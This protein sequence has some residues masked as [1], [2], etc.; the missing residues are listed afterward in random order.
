MTQQNAI[1]IVMIRT[2]NQY[3]Y[4]ESEAGFEV[5]CSTFIGI[6]F[7]GIKKQKVSNCRHLRRN[8]NYIV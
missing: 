5:L 6:P 3:L 2:D 1:K 7:V 4:T 8:I